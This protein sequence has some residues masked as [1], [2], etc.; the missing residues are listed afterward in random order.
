MK[1]GAPLKRS[2]LK[3]QYKSTGPDRLTVEKVWER[4]DGQCAW[5]GDPISGERTVDWSV[6]HRRPR[7]MGGDRRP[8][9]NSPA[10]LVLLHGDGTTRCHGF[11]ESERTVAYDRRMLLHDGDRPCQRQIDHAVHGWVYLT[12]DGEA[13]TEPP[14]EAA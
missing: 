11:I 13:V 5:C 4:D 9:T 7:R 6:H 14:M 8:D 12:D 1:R 10:N 3:R 2:P